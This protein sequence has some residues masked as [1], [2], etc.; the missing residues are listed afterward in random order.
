MNIFSRLRLLKALE[1][2][3]SKDQ[4]QLG[5]EEDIR[6]E[7]AWTMASHPPLTP[8]P[9]WRGVREVEAR[10]RETMA[11]H[12]EMSRRRTSPTAIGR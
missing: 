5:G 9:S 4:P 12:L 11:R 10:E 2:S 7:T 8:T 1:K 3:N 6:L